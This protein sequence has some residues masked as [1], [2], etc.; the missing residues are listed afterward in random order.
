MNHG[1]L[2]QQPNRPYPPTAG[3]HHNP[4][5]PLAAPASNSGR[6]MQSEGCTEEDNGG[7]RHRMHEHEAFSPQQETAK[8]SRNSVQ[9][10]SSQFLSI[11]GICPLSR[12]D[13]SLLP[14]SLKLLTTHYPRFLRSQ[15]SSS[16]QV[17]E[18]GRDLPRGD[19]V[20]AAGQPAKVR[21]A[22]MTMRKRSE[23]SRKKHGQNE[24]RTPVT[25]ASSFVQILPEKVSW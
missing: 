11:L 12:L 21:P 7:R 6:F 1:F 20:V 22:A 14:T 18:V 19:L 16:Q 25:D 10:L 15:P 13:L 4:R 24:A 9:H 3:R 5:R 23:S 8:R 17:V 2:Q